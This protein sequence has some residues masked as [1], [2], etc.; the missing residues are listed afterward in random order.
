MDHVE[1]AALLQQQLINGQ[2]SADQSQTNSPTSAPLATPAVA[3]PP[4]TRQQKTPKSSTPSLYDRGQDTIAYSTG[5]AVAFGLW[6]AGA[7]FTLQFLVGIGVNL[8]GLSWGQWL[9]PIAITACQLRLWPSTGSTWHR[10]GLWLAVL[11]FDIGTSCGGIAKTA[12][13]RSFDIFSGV[14]LPTSGALLWGLAMGVAVLFAFIPEKL[15]RWSGAELL[16]VWR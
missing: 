12:A 16:A 4:S 7:H 8:A 2:A 9:I 5:L 10:W 13:G 11:A 6:L 15:A 3:A 1:R 14:T